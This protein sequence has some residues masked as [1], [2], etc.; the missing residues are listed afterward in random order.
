MEK[1]LRLQ[2]DFPG[3]EF[4][5]RKGM[6]GQQLV[7]D[8]QVATNTWDMGTELLNNIEFS[9]EVKELSAEES[10]YTFL[11]LKVSLYL[12]NK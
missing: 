3:H 7:V 5:V 9:K 4:D 1:L 6:F 12:K 10:L 11:K 8:G 2:T